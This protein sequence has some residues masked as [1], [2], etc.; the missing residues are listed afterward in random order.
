[1]NEVLASM[2][3]LSLQEAKD[4]GIAPEDVVLELSG[5]FRF[6]G[7]T[8]EVNVP[9]ENRDFTEELAERFEASFPAIYEENYGE[10]TAWKDSPVQL[11]NVSLRASSKRQKPLDARV[12]LE[13]S[14]TSP[15][16]VSYREVFLPIEREEAT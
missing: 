3:Q 8:Y 12:P 16:P 4:E 2:R 11:L 13:G 15:K 7:Q 1:V 9:L 5:D 6:L 14:G 10:G